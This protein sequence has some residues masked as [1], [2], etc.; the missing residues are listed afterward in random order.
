MLDEERVK[1][2]TKLAAFEQRED[3]LVFKVNSYMKKDYVTLNVIYTLLSTSLAF[4]LICGVVIATKYNYLLGNIQGMNVF[5]IAYIIIGSWLL[6]ELVLGI[7][8]YRFYSIR[9]KKCKTKI[10]KYVTGLRILEQMY[11]SKEG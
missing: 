1:L 3:R 9:Y 4:M 6:L 8:A 11:E 10:A 7:I 5:N 2:M